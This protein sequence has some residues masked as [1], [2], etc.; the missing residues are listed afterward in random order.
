MGLRALLAVALLHRLAAGLLVDSPPPLLRSPTYSLATLNNDFGG[1]TNMNIL[2]YATPVGVKPVRRWAVGLF[3][4]TRSHANF[5]ARGSGV[6]Q[7]LC[8]A[9][10]PLVYTLG[11]CTGD[12]IDKEAECVSRGFPWIDGAGDKDFPEMLLPGC[13]VY[14][15]LMQEGELLEAGEH[16]VAIC[17][18]ER[19]LAVEGGPAFD[20][21]VDT[22]RLRE[23][24][25]VTEQGRAAPP[26]GA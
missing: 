17:R 24:G 19:T 9:H 21:Q 10:A 8:E 16:D 26:D 18:V 22:G 14:L 12:E 23:L 13:A 7:L 5:V 11:G 15:H 4:G 20:Q 25:L 3:R 1:S 6:L 2:T